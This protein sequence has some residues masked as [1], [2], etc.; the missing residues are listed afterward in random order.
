MDIGVGTKFARVMMAVVTTVSITI[1]AC[2]GPT[3]PPPPGGE[4]P[5]FLINSPVG[6]GL[7]A[8]TFFFSVQPL[9][10]TSVSRVDFEVDGEAV[11]SDS[12]GSD[13]FRV[14]IA[15]RDYGAGPLV[16]EAVVTGANG[17][18]RTRSVTVEN[19]PNP[20]SSTTVGADGAVL[21]TSSGS[22]LGIRPGDAVG[23]NVSFE[24]RTQA[25]VKSATGI[26]YEALAV[27][28]LGAQEIDSDVAIATP[29]MVS[30]A[31]FASRVQPGQAVVN[32]RIAPDANGDGVGELVMVNSA[33]VAG[34][35]VISDPVPQLQLGGAE[36]TTSAGS[37]RIR[38]LQG[39]TLSGPPGARLHIDVQGLNPGAIFGNRL[40]WESSV[41]GQVY[42]V[43]GIVSPDS[44]GSS[45]S[46]ISVPM[47]PLPPGAATLTIFNLSS[48]LSVGPIDVLVEPSPAW[49]ALP[50][51]WSTTCSLTRSDISGVWR[52]RIPERS[53]R[54]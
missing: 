36:V 13:G 1:V 5:M 53:R 33:S 50:P 3:V 27:T 30:S 12:D 16:L 39:D 11:A 52:H 2:T 6:G 21:A 19:V 14:A 49:C 48:G 17:R 7:T 37:S 45:T 25:E 51:R 41:N 35:D 38:T 24:E 10:A 46:T 47:P 44:V 8:G 22:T 42:V 26:D 31:D 20:P 34:D 4:G 43:P 9:N 40:V 15:A 54:Y 29:L 28:F 32:Y 18:S 23:A